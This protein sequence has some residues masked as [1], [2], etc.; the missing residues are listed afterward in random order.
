MVAPNGEFG[1]PSPP[2]INIELPEAVAEG[3]YSN[4]VLVSHSATEFVL[5]FARLLPGPPKGKVH[6][7]IVMTPSHAKSLIA[8]LQENLA[9]FERNFGNISPLSGLGPR[10]P[11]EFDLG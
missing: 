4:L 2:S 10:P 9:G 5:D 1:E 3:I 8:T 11:G 6:A 7:R